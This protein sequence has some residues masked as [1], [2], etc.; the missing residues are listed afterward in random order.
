[1][2]NNGLWIWAIMTA[3]VIVGLLLIAAPAWAQTT[4]TDDFTRTSYPQSDL[5]TADADGPKW[6][7][8]PAEQT[9]WEV[10]LLEGTGQAEV[11]NG[12]LQQGSRAATFTTDL[13]TI[14]VA[15]KILI[16][17]TSQVANVTQGI[18]LRC[19]SATNTDCYAVRAHSGG[20]SDG[21][22]EWGK[23]EGTDG[24]FTAL[25]SVDIGTVDV[26]D[27][28]G[29][30]VKETGADTQVWVWFNDFSAVG[31]QLAA[32][33]NDW[34][35]P[36]IIF[37]ADPGGNAIDT[38]ERVGM[39][40]DLDGITTV[41]HFD[42]FQ[43]HSIE[44]PFM[45]EFQIYRYDFND[46]TNRG[47]DTVPP[48]AHA[49][50]NGTPAFV[51]SPFGDGDALDCQDD[52]STFY[53]TKV[54]IEGI[55]QGF[56]FCASVDPDDLTTAG[57]GHYVWVRSSRWGINMNP[58]T[59]STHCP[60]TEA[61]GLVVTG[62]SDPWVSYGTLSIDTPYR[63]CTTYDGVGE[64]ISYVNGSAITTN[65]TISGYDTAEPTGADG[66]CN[67]S[68]GV[69][70]IHPDAQVDVVESWA[71]VLTPQQVQDDFDSFGG[72]G[73]GDIDAG[74]VCDGANLNGQ[75]CETVGC[76][77]AGLACAST[78]LSFDSSGCSGGCPFTDHQETVPCGPS[79][80]CPS[81]Q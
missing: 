27:S 78:C 21:L 73:N 81:V 46:N 75:T 62:D 54:S 7:I 5:N 37:Q 28:I 41:V 57:N 47:R 58:G 15:A 23:Y 60:A 17:G 36:A 14:D 44:D 56:S 67:T 24:S 25:Q 45:E 10:V 3:I 6:R 51:A 50:A 33:P 71:V 68:N 22:I 79:G 77:G 52:S 34:G 64:M 9:D 66:I 38:G 53:N 39:Y 2:N 11:D 42:D 13:G 48:Y 55:S 70:V 26:G 80:S 35:A 32:D 29:A 74:E 1:M 40:A 61:C 43:A 63:L 30:G 72:C 16:R 76:S 20:G 19:S 59:A 8:E 69:A 12:A 31:G 49:T 18:L 4:G 65:T